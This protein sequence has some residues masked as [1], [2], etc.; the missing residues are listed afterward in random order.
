MMHAPLNFAQTNL[1]LTKTYY[2]K[3][4]PNPSFQL[5]LHTRHYGWV[6]F[7]VPPLPSSPGD[8]LDLPSPQVPT[9]HPEGPK[10]DDMS[11]IGKCQELRNHSKWSCC[12]K[13]HILGYHNSWTIKKK[14]IAKFMWNGVVYGEWHHS[15]SS[16]IKTSWDSWDFQC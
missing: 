14:T 12:L 11:K 13:R 15:R 6:P 7:F 1:P 9:K 2:L 5:K 8:R 10:V 16:K 3:R 4:E